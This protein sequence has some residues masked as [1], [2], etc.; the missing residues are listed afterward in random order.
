[1]STARRRTAG[2]IAVTTAL[3]A[4]LATTLSPIGPAAGTETVPDLTRD[5]D[6]EVAVVEITLPDQ[7]ELDRLVDTGVDL[8]H[9]VHPNADGTLTAHAVITPDQAEALTAS[10]FD[11]GDSVHEDADTEE[12]LAERDATRAAAVAENREFAAAAASAEVSDVKI[13]RADYY[14]SFGV[15]Y[16]SVEAKWAQGQTNSAQLVVER[17]NGAGTELGSGGTQNISRFVDAGVYLYHRGASVVETRPDTIL[18]T[19]PSG[20]VATATVTDWLPLEG[21]DA[22]G[23]AY[24]SDF[25]TS[26]LTPTELYDRIKALAAQFPQISEIVELPHQ[27]NG[28][29]RLAQGVLGTANASRV[30]VDSK[31][32]GHEGGNGI[33]V[34]VVTPAAANAPL[35]VSVTGDAITVSLATNASSAATSTA[36]QVVAAVNASPAASALVTAYTYRGNPGTGVVAA[37]SVT[38][39]PFQ[40]ST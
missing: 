5:A 24:Q 29:R 7:T 26:Y 28:Y 35:S 9:A 1:M 32:W 37:G 40:V 21:D 27:T 16:L 17:D 23:P 10:G 4:L 11:V 25:I 22:F 33:V 3:L 31:A 20:D 18:I 34:S 38:V 8:D 6:E 30:G 12:V 15:G 39:V 14:T 2:G 36:A 19:S 13:I